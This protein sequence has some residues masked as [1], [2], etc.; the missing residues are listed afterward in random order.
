MHT[1]PLTPSTGPRLGLAP[2]LLNEPTTP[3][4]LD[5]GRSR[6][7]SGMQLLTPASSQRSMNDALSRRASQRINATS[8]PP[9]SSSLGTNGTNTDLNDA[10]GIIN[11]QDDGM[12][13][14]FKIQDMLI[15]HYPR[16]A[17][18][19]YPTICTLGGQSAGKS[20]VLSA[21]L[22]ID[23]WCAEGMA[24]HGPTRIASRRGGS[25]K[26]T[27][28]IIIADLRNERTK[29]VDFGEIYDEKDMVEAMHL[30]GEEA[31]PWSQLHG[32]SERERAQYTD[33]ASRWTPITE[34]VVSVVIF[35][36]NQPQFDIYDMPG[37]NGDQ[38]I[39]RLA[40]K[41]I[42]KQ[43][44]IILLCLPGGGRDASL[45]DPEV[46]LV[47]E[48]DPTGSRT[49]A[50]ITRADETSADP[51][52][53]ST[54]ISYILG[55]SDTLGITPAG[56]IW[57]VQCRS[58]KQRRMQ[59][60]LSEVRAQEEA[61]FAEPDWEAVQAQAGRRYGTAALATR[62]ETL[63]AA[64]IQENY[65]AIRQILRESNQGNFDWLHEHPAIEDPIATLHDD[66]IQAFTDNLNREMH[67]SNTS[68]KLYDL[69]AQLEKT[70]MAAVPELLAFTEDEAD[71]RVWTSFFDKEGH[72]VQG[73]DAIYMDTLLELI[74]NNT[75]KR[76]PTYVNTHEIIQDHLQAYCARWKT[77]ALDHPE[78]LWGEVVNLQTKVAGWVCGDNKALT[79]KVLDILDPLAST[80]VN[81][82]RDF[83][84]V[85]H[86]VH[87]ASPWHLK[88]GNHPLIRKAHQ[89]T[90]DHFRRQ[91][92]TGPRK[93][94][95]LLGLTSP[96]T[97]T[98]AA[99]RP[100]DEMY[101]PHEREKCFQLQST[102]AT[103][104]FGNAAEFSSVVGQFAQLQVLEYV[105]QVS[106]TLRKGM[107]LEEVQEDVYTRVSNWLETDKSTRKERKRRLEEVEQN[108]ELERQLTLAFADDE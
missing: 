56:G 31:R 35:G 77:A 51:E 59:V 99:A 39:K 62:L 49:L 65:L 60:T 13:K 73:R 28:S 72:A 48:H 79:Q 17:R 3:T 68:A 26:A 87:S 23:L 64:K 24:T 15:K 25:F 85:M 37:T 10:T 43:H 16:D 106:R 81:D 54:W 107:R 9:A 78:A 47:R 21:L 100:L 29:I 44:N 61:L 91:Y 19:P 14:Y 4:P 34:N 88:L 84:S 102:L 90:T 94:S 33:E 1:S 86:K 30:A 103:T 74:K 5:K 38:R 63:F 96:R 71:G 6:H 98:S 82:T 67:R 93:E 50:V 7:P 53:R 55:E 11:A 108:M 8:R 57:P 105:K 40:S 42:S 18:V 52:D 41:Y 27:I 45:D 89:D 75:S 69:H 20:S 97:P 95:D 76:D 101:T 70:I 58:R 2:T 46:Q 12:T 36:P 22:N 80:F 83:I 66:I 104:L 92:S 32:M